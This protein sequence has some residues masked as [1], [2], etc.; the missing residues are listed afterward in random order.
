M[1]WP[2]S[3]TLSP[4]GG[5]KLKPLG[6]VLGLKRRRGRGR[7]EN[8]SLSPPPSPFPLT[9]PKFPLFSIQYGGFKQSKTRRTQWKRLQGKLFKRGWCFVKTVEYV[10]PQVCDTSDTPASCLHTA[11]MR[12]D[13][14]GI[15]GFS[16]DPC[17]RDK[18]TKRNQKSTVLYLVHCCKNTNLSLKISDLSLQGWK[19]MSRN[20]AQGKKEILTCLLK[21]T[22]K[23]IQR[24]AVNI[25]DIDITSESA[26]ARI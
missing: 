6:L 5:E 19:N 8:I 26:Q 15:S 23:Q 7:G 12:R 21:T 25:S 20:L 2:P 22:M 3:L 14:R 13:H 11:D 4:R 24:R 16:F 1:P 9:R 10:F 17:R 18:G